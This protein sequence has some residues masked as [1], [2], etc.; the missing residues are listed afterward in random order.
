MSKIREGPSAKRRKFEAEYDEV[1]A[2]AKSQGAAHAD[3]FGVLAMLCNNL[4]VVLGAV[5]PKF[6]YAGARIQR[7]DALSLGQ[8]AH[9]SPSF[10]EE[11]Q[12]IN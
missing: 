3:A 10:V 6:L 1:V 2:A 4:P 12:W 11:L 7:L 9:D 8:L 5:S